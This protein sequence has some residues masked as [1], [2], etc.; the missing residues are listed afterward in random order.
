MI[1]DYHPSCGSCKGDDDSQKFI[2]VTYTR[3]VMSV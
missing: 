2:E 1:Y 3:V